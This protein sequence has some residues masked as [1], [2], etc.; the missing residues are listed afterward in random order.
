MGAA[1]VPTTRKP[2]PSMRMAPGSLAVRGGGRLLPDYVRKR[3]HAAPG[4]ST[5]RAA[6]ECGQIEQ[7]N[8]SILRGR[9]QKSGGQSQEESA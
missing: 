4:N 1:D 3:M 8:L 5:V 6:P 2:G 9:R 7:Q